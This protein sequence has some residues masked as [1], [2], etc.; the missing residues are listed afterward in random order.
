M[1]KMIVTCGTFILCLAFVIPMNTQAFTKEMP[2][3][4]QTGQWQVKFGKYAHEQ[5]NVYN[6]YNSHDLTVKNIGQHVSDVKVTGFKDQANVK[7]NAIIK[8]SNKGLSQGYAIESKDF[9]L[10]YDINKFVVVISWTSDNDGKSHQQKFVF[11]E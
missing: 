5:N 8:L 2:V 9:P 6:R 1:K 11:T 3:S 4:K 10:S 7:A